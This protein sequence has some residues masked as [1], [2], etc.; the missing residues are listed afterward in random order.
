MR[1]AAVT[2]VL[3]LCAT[4]CSHAQLRSAGDQMVRA[5]RAT[6]GVVTG[7]VAFK[8]ATKE[9]CIAQNLAT[10]A[11]RA[12]CVEKALAA[13]QASRVGV[14]AVR[15]ALVTFWELYP[16]LD[17][18]LASGERLAAEDL[19]DLVARGAAVAEAYQRLI[20]QVQE[21]KR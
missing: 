6:E 7:V 4:G 15:A 2:L 13:V 12:T 11:E 17:A 19:A 3:A 16:V 21:A 8:E 10:E 1:S 20:T 5:E 9:D 14:E 18:K